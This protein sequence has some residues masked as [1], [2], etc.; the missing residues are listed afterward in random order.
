MAQEIKQALD[1][2]TDEWGI[3]VTAVEI[4][5]VIVDSQLEIAIA[6]EVAEKEK[7]KS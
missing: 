2:M 6:R 3:K 7:S 4:R 1:R 5:E